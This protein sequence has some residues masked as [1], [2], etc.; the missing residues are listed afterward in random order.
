MGF[1][2]RS[3]TTFRVV[4]Y[5][6]RDFFRRALRSTAARHLYSARDMEHT[7]ARWSATC[8]HHN[9]SFE[10]DRIETGEANVRGGDLDALDG[11]ALL[12][13]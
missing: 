4:R 2:G 7:R 9:I 10:Y 5:A 8:K 11:K 6:R 1:T 13:K 3:R 12:Q